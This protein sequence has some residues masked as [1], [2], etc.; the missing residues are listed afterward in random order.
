M[1]AIAPP[2][3]AITEAQWQAQLI[4]LAGYY[5]WRHFHPY[6]SRRSVEGWPDL[7]L[8]RPP[9]LVI[10][11]LKAEKGRPTRA[12]RRWLDDLAECG[13]EVHIWRPSDFDAAHTRLK[14]RC[15]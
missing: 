15:P 10:V 6:D 3:P 5:G 4:E 13:V 14:R 11:E 12:Q 8:V 7:V 9:E 2:L 1:T